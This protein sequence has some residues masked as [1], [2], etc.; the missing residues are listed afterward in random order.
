ERKAIRQSTNE[1]FTRYYKDRMLKGIEAEREECNVEIRRL[2]IADNAA[3][4]KLELQNKL[5]RSRVENKV[6]SAKLYGS[7]LV[8]QKKT[9][10]ENRIQSFNST[11][12][13]VESVKSVVRNEVSDM[14][15]TLCAYSYKNDLV[16]GTRI[17]S[18]L[19]Q[20]L[21]CHVPEPTYRKVQKRGLFGRVIQSV[22]D[23]IDMGE[24]WI[25]DGMEYVTNDYKTPAINKVNGHLDNFLQ[26]WNK[27]L[28]DFKSQRI[29]KNT[30]FTP[31]PR[32]AEI[33]MVIKQLSELEEKMNTK[34]KLLSIMDAQSDPDK[35]VQ[36]IS[37]EI[38]R[39][40]NSI[41]QLPMSG[42]MCV[43]LK[44]MLSEWENGSIKVVLEGGYACGKTTLLCALAKEPWLISLSTYGAPLEII[45]CQTEDK[46][47]I[48]NAVTR[49]STVMSAKRFS[50]T[51]YDRLYDHNEETT[52]CVKGHGL[53]TSMIS[54][55][56]NFVY[57]E[58][59]DRIFDNRMHADALVLVIPAIRAFSKD[60]R[61]FFQ[62]LYDRREDLFVVFTMMDSFQEN[63]E[64]V[65]EE[66]VKMMRTILSKTQ[67]GYSEA[68]IRERV[69]FTKAHVEMQALKGETVN[70]GGVHIPAEMIKTG[71]PELRVA[72]KNY[73]FEPNRIK[74]SVY[75]IFRYMCQSYGALTLQCSYLA[76]GLTMARDNLNNMSM[77]LYGEPLTDR[78]RQEIA[79]GN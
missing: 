32:I 4:E 22:V 10:I 36:G 12:I 71:I 1:C 45:P 27:L 30:A 5:N 20:F 67:R 21:S 16:A 64:S 7:S 42:N 74:A 37:E 72:L 2:Q 65:K 76:P 13:F 59:D 44:D 49:K 77:L 38:N 23:T 60:D 29:G 46:V 68:F 47:I 28:N 54:L 14:I 63:E 18:E 70:A 51:R 24:L 79:N 9:S 17:R 62:E 73:V 11:S 41:M 56:D 25:D 15:G 52:I 78:R 55:V 75:P 69:F 3:K 53:G 39:F 40:R 50:E 35:M 57:R 31:N 33:Q 66:L 61:E 58:I 26:R 6:E 19:N 43:K 48:N 34:E 8:K